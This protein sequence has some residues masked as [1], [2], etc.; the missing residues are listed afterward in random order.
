M[1]EVKARNDREA[2]EIDNVFA[3]RNKSERER[4]TETERE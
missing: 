1:E 3:D 4:E 2:A